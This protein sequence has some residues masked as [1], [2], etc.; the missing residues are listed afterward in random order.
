MKFKT[1]FIIFNIIIVFS[2]LVIFLMPLFFL[3][4]IQFGDFFRGNW[5]IVIIFAATL[6][7]FNAYFAYNWR[8]FRLLE[9]EDWKGLIDFLERQVYDKNRLTRAYVRL[10]INTYLVT[11]DP[12]AILRLKNRVLNLK[13]RLMR[14]FALPLG[15][16][17]LLLGRPAEAESYFG[18]YLEEKGVADRDWIRWNYGF[19]LMQLKQW[20]GAREE[21]QAV[22]DATRKPILTLLSF[23]LMESVPDLGPEEERRLDA[24]KARLADRYDRR[25]WNRYVERRR[26][27]LN[28]LVFSKLIEEATDW[29]FGAAAGRVEETVH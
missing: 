11:S 28:V 13:P 15:L 10:L 26:G 20:K 14:R 6:L 17:Y 8:L 12:E 21:F 23:Y 18:K 29:L 9:N 4:G 24:E 22:V 3:G 25:S 7:V 19:C 2:F 16:P 5:Y 27:D 1:I